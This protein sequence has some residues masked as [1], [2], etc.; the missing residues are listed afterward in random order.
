MDTL[1]I[2]VAAAS[3]LGAALW[4]ARKRTKPRSASGPQAPRA[5]A[6]GRPPNMPVGFGR[7]CMWLA[8]RGTDL[9]AVVVELALT[10]CRPAS[11]SEGVAAG[12]DG[13]KST[14]FV[15]PPLDG[16][17]LVMG[18]REPSPDPGLLE[19]LSIRFG[20]VQHFATHRGASAGGWSRAIGGNVQRRVEFG[21][22][23]LIVAKGPLSEIEQELGLREGTQVEDRSASDDSEASDEQL[24]L[25]EE[26]VLRVAGAWSL[27]P[28]TLDSRDEPRTPG[29]L[30]RL[31]QS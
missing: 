11:W 31:R 4:L 8:V 18:T 19:R 7:K 12:Y 29:M 24:F 9:Q 25:D 26:E 23:V 17:V 14:V 6:S 5:A 30:G 15:T 22:G 20:E 13:T 3:G 21:D 2:G 27:D 10:E 28:T 1:W 16:W